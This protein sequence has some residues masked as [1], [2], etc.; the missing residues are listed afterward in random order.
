MGRIDDL[1][2]QS[3]SPF[4]S[5]GQFLAFEVDLLEQ[6]RDHDSDAQ[7]QNSMHVHRE[8]PERIRSVRDRSLGRVPGPHE[9]VEDNSGHERVPVV[10]MPVEGAD[11]HA[12]PFRDLVQR[13]VGTALDENVTGCREDLPVVAAGVSP[14]GTHPIR[15]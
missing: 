9:S 11:A 6:D 13:R 10:E 12:G 4:A 1:L 8:R 3:C 15:C 2:K 14:P 5:R 7:V